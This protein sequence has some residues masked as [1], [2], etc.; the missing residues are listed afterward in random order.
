MFA[1]F[2]EKLKATQDGDG[3]LLDHSALVY[4]SGMSHGNVHSHENLPIVL[5][6]G[7]GGQIRGGRHLVSP[8]GTPA[9][10]LHLALAEKYGVEVDIFADATGRV[11]L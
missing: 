9:S 3:T 5:V 1:Y 2:L 6:G 8:P 11:S 4:G 10:N 7:L